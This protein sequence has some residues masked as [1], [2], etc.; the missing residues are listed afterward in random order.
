[1]ANKNTKSRERLTHEMRAEVTKMMER[2]LDYAEVACPRDTFKQL[3]S[4]VL[5]IGNDCMRNLTK[6]FDNYDMV[7]NKLL[8][9]IIEFRH[10][11]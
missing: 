8:E 9:E 2:T 4:K 1:M 11:G 5:R 10:K 3:R 7:Y 6:T